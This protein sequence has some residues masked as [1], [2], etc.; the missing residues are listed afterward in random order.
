[1]RSYEKVQSYIKELDLGKIMR[2]FCDCPENPC[3]SC[4]CDM[5]STLEFVL[6]NKFW[7]ETMI[8]PNTR[9]QDI[10]KEKF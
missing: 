9:A 5:Q 4:G 2:A 7:H 10:F 3:F 8:F 1:L 6:Q